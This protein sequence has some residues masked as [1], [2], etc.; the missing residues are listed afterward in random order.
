MKA[1]GAAPDQRKRL[2][3]MVDALCERARK[4]P[5]QGPVV[6]THG[7]YHYEHVFLDEET[8][9]VIDFDRSRP[10]DPARDLAEFVSM[11]RLRTFKLLGS[12]TTADAPTRLFLHEYAARLPGHVVNL[13][14]HW[15]AC[16]LLNMCRYVKK[17]EP[18]NEAFVRMME[19]YAT[20]FDAVLSGRFEPGIEP[21]TGDVAAAA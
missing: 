16:L 15:G 12:T 7:R 21:P 9:T 4:G 18:G 2:I 11:L 17:H 6:Q 3:G 1:A 13:A 20:E 14:V 8:V 5:E 19:F 10:S